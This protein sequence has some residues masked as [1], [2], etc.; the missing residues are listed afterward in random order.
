MLL[1]KNAIIEYIWYNVI[2]HNLDCSAEQ[3]ELI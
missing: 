3:L 2:K 1:I